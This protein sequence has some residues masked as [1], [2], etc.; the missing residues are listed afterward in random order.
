LKEANIVK[1]NSDLNN[2]LNLN[3]VSQ[4]SQ[5]LPDWLLK[6]SAVDTKQNISNDSSLIKTLKDE[7]TRTKCEL[8]QQT[9]QRYELEQKLVFMSNAFTA[10][11]KDLNEKVE[12]KLSSQ[13]ETTSRELK[14]LIDQFTQE[15]EQKIIAQLGLKY[16]KEL[17][18]HLEA[19]LVE[20]QDKLI[21][22]TESKYEDTEIKIKNM[23]LSAVKEENAMEK[24]KLKQ[25]FESLERYLKSDIEKQA[26]N[27]FISQSE[28]FKE[29]IKSAVMQEHLIHKDLI[30]NK[31]EKIQKNSDEKRKKTNQLY[32]RHL[33]GLNFFIDNA[34]KQLSILKAAHQEM[35][36]NKE[37]LDDFHTDINYNSDNL[38]QN[39][40][41]MHKDFDKLSLTGG[42]RRST[43]LD[44]E[45]L[46]ENLLKE[47]N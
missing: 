1:N 4:D 24:L 31:L 47:L 14:R 9:K 23:V 33:S 8:E 15:K 34:H 35:Y 13:H 45:L 20:F 39:E 27:H 40:L 16:Q 22:Y 7:L 10:A 29:Q 37:L 43:E 2:N 19:K 5:V 44:D 3:L 12:L 42:S 28:L 46:D 30:S 32:S 41:Y 18:E 17:N 21:K 25:Q 38:T 6:N 26:I 36:K 11:I